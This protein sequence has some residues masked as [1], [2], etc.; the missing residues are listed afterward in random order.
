METENRVASR[1][2]FYKPKISDKPYHIISTMSLVKEGENYEQFHERLRTSQPDGSEVYSLDYTLACF[3][4]PRLKLLK[5]QFNNHPRW[6]KKE[7]EENPTEENKIS[8]ERYRD[9]H[10]A[11]NKMIFTFNWYSS[12][13]QWSYDCQDEEWN[14]RIRDGLDAFSEHYEA[15]WF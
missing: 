11:L 12:D 13:R 9:F 15:L 10:D 5:R 14:K 7:L 8:Y 2:S 3:L 1:N 4:L 6:L